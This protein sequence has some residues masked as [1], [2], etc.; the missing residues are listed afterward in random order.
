M[1]KGVIPLFKSCSGFSAFWLGQGSVKA[2]STAT[3]ASPLGAILVGGIG[4]TVTVLDLKDTVNIF[5]NETG[6]T[7]CTVT[8]LLLDVLGIALGTISFAQA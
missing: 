7:L 3:I 4:V 5:K 2:M 1:I 6:P 8:R